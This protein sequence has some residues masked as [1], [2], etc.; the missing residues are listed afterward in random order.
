MRCESSG[1]LLALREDGAL[2]PREARRMAEHLEGCGRCRAL[3]RE[4]AQGRRWIESTPPPPLAQEDLAAVRRGVWRV[5]E[6]R[7][8]DSSR[9]AFVA[10]ALGF[11]AAGLAAVALGVI[12]L[13]RRAPEPALERL[14]LP[15]AAPLTT[16]LPGPSSAGKSARSAVPA[17]ASSSV[18]PAR[19]ARVVR[20]AHRRAVPA[21]EPGF[22]RIEFRTANPNVRVIWLVEKGR[23]DS[24]APPAGRNQEVS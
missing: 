22:S 7:G 8:L 13:A 1:K 15:T 16:A 19:A 2:S 10:R 4:L 20:A 21:G 18:S 14:A 12:W 11:A 17:A 6:A 5:I 3:Q 24:A 23:G 9:S